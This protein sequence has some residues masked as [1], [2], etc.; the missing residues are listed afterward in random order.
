MASMMPELNWLQWSIA[1]ITAFSIGLTKTGIAG[2][3][4]LFIPLMAEVFPARASTGI[5]LPMLMFA[6]IF[7]VAYYRKH[8]VWSHLLKLMPWT[9]IGIVMGYLALGRVDDAQLKPIIG[10]IILVMLLINFLLGH[11]REGTLIRNSR[12]FAIGMGIA[13]GVTTMMANVAGTIVSIYFL[14]MKLP[15]TDFIG[16][17]SWFFLI[18]NW[19]KVPFSMSLGLITI[20]S[21]QLNIM[22]FP[23]VALG[24]LV[25]I[26]SLK[27]IPERKFGVIV[28]ILAA[29]S[30]ASLFI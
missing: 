12:W 14:A 30:A 2:L 22:I 7:A 19:F 26:L 1:I 18:L 10:A 28:Q 20:D 21:L 16:T 24:A 3:S 6:D 9:A 4:V 5:V 25:G 29:I 8:A 11:G 13:A 15:K 23:A 17:G 27:R